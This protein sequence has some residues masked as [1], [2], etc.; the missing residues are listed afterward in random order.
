MTK[1][2]IFQYTLS[3][4]DDLF[5]VLFKKNKFIYLQNIAI[6]LYINHLE[7]LKYL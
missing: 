3:M 6:N 7:Y 5:K 1:I 2:S 4:Q